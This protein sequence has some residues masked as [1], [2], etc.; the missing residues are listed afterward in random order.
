MKRSLSQAVVTAFI[1][2][3]VQSV[4]VYADPLNVLWYTWADP[5][6]E[7]RASG[8]SAIAAD[9]ATNAL[10]AGNSWTITQWDDGAPVPTL[11]DYDVLVIESGAPFRTGAVPGTFWPTATAYDGILGNKSAIEAVRG[12]R[13][14]ITATDADFHAIRGDSGNCAAFSGCAVW[15]G[16]RGHLINAIDWAGSGNGLGVVALLNVNEFDPNPNLDAS[17]RY[18]WDDSDSFLYGE[19]HGYFRT[20]RSSNVASITPLAA[21]L[22]LNEGLTALGLSNWRNSFHGEFLDGTPGYSEV[23]DSAFNTGYAYTIATTAT[24]DAGRG[25]RD[26]LPVREPLSAEMLLLGLGVVLAWSRRRPAGM[27]RR[28]V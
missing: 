9:A 6:S 4:A 1:G 27:A 15:D 12:D 25:G 26:A 3:A 8:L 18:W 20:I 19:L 5:A 13:T 17:N 28:P 24:I 2:F 21:D 11:A 7:Y 16:A 23:V 22:P 14:F 10:S